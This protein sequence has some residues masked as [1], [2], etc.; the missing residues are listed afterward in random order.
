MLISL[1]TRRIVAV[2]HFL[3]RQADGGIKGGEE[4]RRQEEYSREGKSGLG[5][6]GEGREKRCSAARITLREQILKLTEEKVD[7][8]ISAL[9]NLLSV[10]ILRHAEGE[11]KKKKKRLWHIFS[12]SEAPA[13][14]TERGGVRGD[15][16]QQ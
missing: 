15:G 1:H 9:V 3:L 11:S 16:W 14:L 5:R 6:D 2:K 8:H 13:H 10:A 7:I 4:R 12:V